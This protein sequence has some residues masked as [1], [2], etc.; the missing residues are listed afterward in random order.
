M[1][2]DRESASKPTEGTVR[3]REGDEQSRTTG[4]GGSRSNPTD[5]SQ[6]DRVESD[7]DTSDNENQKRG[8]LK[9]KNEPRKQGASGGTNPGR[10]TQRSGQST[11]GSKPA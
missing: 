11:G 3:P 4:Q 7:E 1:P 10:E 2:E 9:E 6:R 8:E 5:P